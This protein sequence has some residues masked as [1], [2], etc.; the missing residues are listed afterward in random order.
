MSLPYFKP[1]AVR[2]K[3]KNFA[4]PSRLISTSYNFTSSLL[5]PL[6]HSSLPSIHR[7]YCSL[8]LKCPKPFTP[9]TNSIL[10]LQALP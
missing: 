9:F 7:T 10:T 2:M 6:P 8:F 5:S 1:F 4:C 3:F